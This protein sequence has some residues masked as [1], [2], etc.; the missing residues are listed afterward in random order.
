MTNE[1]SSYDLLPR[2]P[3]SGDDMRTRSI[4][5][6]KARFNSIYYCVQRLSLIFR[7]GVGATLRASSKFKVSVILLQ[8]ISRN[9]RILS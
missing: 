8:L 3:F 9:A 1:Q 2:A 7:N 6:Y 5:V 4:S